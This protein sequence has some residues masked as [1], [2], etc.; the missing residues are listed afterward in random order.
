[1]ILLVLITLYWHWY[2]SS[3][4]S[5]LCLTVCMLLLSVKGNPMGAALE[6]R[7]TPVI[8]AVGEAATISTILVTTAGAD[9]YCR[10]PNA[11][12]L[13]PIGLASACAC[14]PCLVSPYVPGPKWPDTQ[15]SVR[16]LQLLLWEHFL[17]G[18]IVGW[19]RILFPPCRHSC[20]P[21]RWTTWNNIETAA[22][23]TSTGSTK[24]LKYD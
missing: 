9:V 2:T 5:L 18:V 23:T 3:E 17:V 22:D 12:P 13:S 16:S 10:V 8:A 19:R 14:E 6:V 20:T 4:I 21:F 24:S 1:M 11:L 15:R 7:V